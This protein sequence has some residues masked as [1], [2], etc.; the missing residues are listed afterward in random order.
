MNNVVIDTVSQEKFSLS[1][2]K[3]NS[4]QVEIVEFNEGD[5]GWKKPITKHK[6]LLFVVSNGIIILKVCSDKSLISIK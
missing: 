3:R 6:I 5:G 4:H 2:L 1:H